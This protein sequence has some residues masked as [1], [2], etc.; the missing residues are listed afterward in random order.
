MKFPVFSLAAL[1]LAG[2]ALVPAAVPGQSAGEGFVAKASV[3]QGGG[4]TAPV[5]VSIERYTTETEREAIVAA[6]KS[7]GTAAVKAALEKAGDLGTIEIGG[8]KTPIKYAYARSTGSGR[9]VT[10]VTAKPILFLGATLPNPKPK[11]GFDLGV[12]MLVLDGNGAGDGEFAPAAKVGTN[13]AGA[14]VIS[15]YGDDKIWLKEVA[16]AK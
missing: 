11:A 16:K 6:V 5:R 2:S 9:I 10:V 3:S 15:D 14:I 12:A 13:E 7:G 8:R 4:A 1:A